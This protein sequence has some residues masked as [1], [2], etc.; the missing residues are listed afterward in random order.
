MS[1]GEWKLFKTKKKTTVEHTETGDSTEHEL[2]EYKSM[3]Q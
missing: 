2:T 1:V 3:S